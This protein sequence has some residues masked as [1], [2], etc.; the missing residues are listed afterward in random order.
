MTFL[1]DAAKWYNA[2]PHQIKAWEALEAKIPQ[3]LIDEFKT[4]Y[5]GSQKPPVA[6]PPTAYKGDLITKEVFEQLT[7]Y[8]AHLFTQQECDD[9]NKMLK[10]TGF[11]KDLDAVCM[12]M[13][14]ILH[15][16][17]NMR[18]LKELA[19]GEA[20]EW[21][22]DLGNVSPGDG[23]RYKGAGVLQLTGRYNYSRL[24][25]SLNDP[26]VMEGCDYVAK[27]Y[28]F[29]SAVPWIRENNLLTIAKTKG[30]EA[31]C[32]RIN[33]GYNGYNDRL[34]KYRICERVFIG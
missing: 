31:V 21:R 6:V 9:C 8:Q 22:S 7:G 24:S 12:L 25:K 4:A 13:A 1:I 33:G 26:R 15:E 29:R 18:W 5:R 23:P 16:T 17:G 28:P 11:I 32:V 19:S 14:N 10:E 3:Y 30:F 2:E 34:K 27:T 20:Y